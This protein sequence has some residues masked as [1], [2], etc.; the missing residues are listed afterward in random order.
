MRGRNLNWKLF[1]EKKD[2]TGNSITSIAIP[3]Q[4]SEINFSCEFTIER[5]YEAKVNKSN[6]KIYNLSPNT[7]KILRKDKFETNEFDKISFYAGS[8]G[9]L[10]LI[11]QGNVLQAESVDVREVDIITEIVALD[12]SFLTYNSFSN[13]TINSN[14]SYKNV[15]DKFFNDFTKKAVEIK[16]TFS[17]EPLTK[18]TTDFLNTTKTK[19]PLTLF[20]N[21][22]EEMKKFFGDGLFIDNGK[23]NFLPINFIPQTQVIILKAETGLKSVPKVSNAVLEVELIFSPKIKVGDMVEIQTSKDNFFN[24]KQFK[25]FGVKHSGNISQTTETRLN[26]TLSLG[27][28]NENIYY[29]TL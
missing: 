27:R 21:T 1:Y 25:V 24:G 12:G 9:D 10:S 11:F 7:R 4:D 16:E 20:G 14:V 26:T 28:F 15:F 3:S 2:K 19:Q 18:E 22:W 6:I 13:H 29:S 23:L 8:E 5:N 17:L